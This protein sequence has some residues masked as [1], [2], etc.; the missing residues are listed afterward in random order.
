MGQRF[1]KADLFESASSPFFFVA[2]IYL[3]CGLS[4]QR[5]LNALWRASD[6]KGIASDGWVRD[7]AL[8][9]LPKL[10]SSGNRLLMQFNTWRPAGCRQAST[11]LCDQNE[12]KFVV[13]AGS[14]V[15]VSLK[16]DC[17]PHLL[18][19]HVSNPFV[20]SEKRYATIARTVN[21]TAGYFA[22]GSSHL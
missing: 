4:Y 15:E 19:F 20:P 1:F 5:S 3:A 9:E 8:L 11:Q 2:L 22:F 16:A 17:N 14:K 18:R 12:T 6:F 10:Y 21:R 7:D 13:E